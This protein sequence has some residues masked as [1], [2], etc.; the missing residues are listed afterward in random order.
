[1]D[2]QNLLSKISEYVVYLYSEERSEN[3]I[4]K[5]V[6]DLR[7]FFVYLADSEI[8]KAAVLDWKDK[9]TK[10]YAPTSVNSMLAVVNSFFDCWTCHSLR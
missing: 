10:E 9:L 5:Y 8:G 3:T 4:T 7:A 1:M 2:N 6:R